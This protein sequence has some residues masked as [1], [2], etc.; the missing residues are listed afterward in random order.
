MAL[1]SAHVASP[2][3]LKKRRKAWMNGGKA[4]KLPLILR[5]FFR[6]A[7]FVKHAP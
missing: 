3:A 5:T 4:E 6:A 2:L 7:A 1:K